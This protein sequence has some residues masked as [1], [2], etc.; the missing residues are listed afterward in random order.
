LRYL[1]VKSWLRLALFLSLVFSPIIFA[2]QQQNLAS[3]HLSEK[4]QALLHLNEGEPQI[5][6]PNFLLSHLNFSPKNEL[7][8]TI[9]FIKESP[10]QAVCRFPA[11][12]IFLSDYIDLDIAKIKRAEQCSELKRYIDF[13]P[14]DNVNLIFASEVVSSASSMMGH[15]FMNVTGNNVNDEGVS[16]S[17]SFF[18]EFSTLNP[19]SLFYDATIGGMNGYFI[20]RPYSV[21]IEQ[22]VDKEGRNLWSY[23]LNLSEQDK[24]LLKYHIWELKNLEINYLFQS[25]NCATLTLYLL[26]IAKPEL[27]NEEKLFVIPIDVVKASNKHQLVSKQDVILSREWELYML[28][29]NLP[30][31]VLFQLN[32]AIKNNTGLDFHRLD[33]SIR[34]MAKRYLYRLNTISPQLFLK[35]H[36]TIK[37]SIVNTGLN[38]SSQFKVDLTH[39][40]NPTKTPQDSAIGISY[41]QDSETDYI[42]FTFMPASHYLY[43][44]NTQYF[45]ES[46]LRIGEVILRSNM[47]TKNISLQAFTLYSMKSLMPSSEFESQLSG[48]FFLGLKST[49]ESALNEKLVFELSGAIGKT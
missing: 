40:K 14:F 12:Y 7:L 38:S 16:H 27:R 5:L 46:A 6:D 36:P 8:A 42:D 2:Y 20:V 32:N 22:Y 28:E 49:F 25:Y 18:T 10:K 15:T 44:D 41:L 33:N 39:Y 34:S 23:Q 9:K 30:K 31:N 35:S 47:E 43:G 45:S 26:S 24:V 48:E 1:F 29:N 21:D 19:I 3:L 13:V 4:W 37:D 11:R 17:V